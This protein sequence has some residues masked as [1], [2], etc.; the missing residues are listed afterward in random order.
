MVFS[1][2]T[3]KLFKTITVILNFV[4][5]D[6]A[7]ML[8]I[9]PTPIGNLSDMTERA[10]EQLAAC[11]FIIAE[12]PS[13]SQKLL[14]HF[15]IGKKPFVQFAD[16]NE[17]SI[18]EEL[19]DRLRSENGCLLSDAGTPGI[20]DPG[21]RLVRACREAGVDVIALPGPNAAVT[22]LSASG[23]PTDRFLF[24]GFLPKTEHKVN[25]LLEFAKHTESTLVGY[26][27]PQRI[28]KTL[29]FIN[30]NEPG[31]HAVVARELTKVHEEYLSGKPAEL[32]SQLESRPIVK[33]EITLLIAFK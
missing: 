33:G 19:T 29:Q 20:S 15:Q 31:A 28:L 3:D 7:Y 9:V 11:D 22:A 24:V 8:Y 6:I 25:E 1:S 4:K 21:F 30:N 23:L 18:V 27:S 12:N 5:D 2:A 26:E 10:K 14:Q 17:R 32:I 16:F 13:Y